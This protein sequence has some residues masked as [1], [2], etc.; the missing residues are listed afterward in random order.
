MTETGASR[1]IV[2][3][4]IGT[5]DAVA[6]LLALSTPDVQVEAIMTV[7]GNTDVDSCVRNARYVLE[8]CGATVPVYRGAP[9]PL[10]RPPTIRGPIHGTDGLGGLGL[11][12]ID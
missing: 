8:L 6:L 5:D 9:A 4:D 3:T 2:D 12:P 1:I 10:S 11:R 7:A